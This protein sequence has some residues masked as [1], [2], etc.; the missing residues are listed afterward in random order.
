MTDSGITN[1]GVSLHLR[2]PDGMVLRLVEGRES[3]RYLE[4]TI[5]PVLEAEVDVP[6]TIT[7]EIA[8]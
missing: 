7:T 4:T 5:L 3:R 1:G 8:F 6:A 2:G